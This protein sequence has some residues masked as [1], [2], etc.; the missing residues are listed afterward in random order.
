MKLEMKRRS[1]FTLIELLVVIA[2][3]A[4]LAALI[5]PALGA[6]KSR[7]TRTVCVDNL[8]QIN[9]GVQMYASEH[10]DL[11]TLVTTNFSPNVWMEYR[12]WMGSYVGLPGTPSPQDTLFACPADTFYY[13]DHRRIAQGL[14]QEPQYNYSSYAFNAGNIRS[15]YNI[16]NQFPGIAGLNLT[17][18]KN[19]A[20]TVLVTE[21]CSQY[22]YSWHQP[23][24]LPA[25]K[26]G[27]NDSPCV[28]SFVDGHVQNIKMYL[29]AYT[30][31]GHFQAWHYDPPAGYDYQWSGN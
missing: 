9:L 22:P 3:I 15:D 28:V 8:K 10:G 16:P 20:R 25:K 1:A 6:A 31:R 26:Y 18:I 2:I 11:L 5:F 29:D 23:Q 19:P 30:A 27:I 13:Y 7:A 21:S 17:S 24:A 4:I 12:K 14:H